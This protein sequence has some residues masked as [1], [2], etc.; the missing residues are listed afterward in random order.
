MEILCALFS[1]FC[2]SKTVVEKTSNFK[3]KKMLYVIRF[4]RKLIMFIE[5]LTAFR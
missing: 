2:K 3:R 1:L 4:S 5:S